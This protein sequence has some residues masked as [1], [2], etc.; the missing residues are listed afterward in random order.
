MQVEVMSLFLDNGAV[1]LEIDNVVAYW[2]WW[3]LWIGYLRM[4]REV[5]FLDEREVNS[6]QCKQWR[7]WA[8]QGME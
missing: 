4:A 2:G 3:C 8:R 7:G 1:V 5:L 6:L